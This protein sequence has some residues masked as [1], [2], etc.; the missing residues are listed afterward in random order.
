[1]VVPGGGVMSV[2]ITNCGALGWVTDRKG[3][4]YSATDPE[5]GLPWP[6][7]P[8]VFRGLAERA[9]AAAGFAGFAPDACLINR[10]APGAKMGLHRDY[11]EQDLRA[12]IVSVS[13]GLPA[14]FLWGGRAR[15][16]KTV[17]VPVV[18]GDVVVFGGE[19]RL[20]YHGVATVKDGVDPVLGRWRL[21]LT[22][23]KA[24]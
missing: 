16:D 12:P 7:M 5:R 21:N 19:G 18:N 14:V 17:K 6:A 2:G 23:R 20:H 24:V 10:Y 1:M 4:R 11:D 9:A 3:Y 8:E 15:A 22:F 13:L